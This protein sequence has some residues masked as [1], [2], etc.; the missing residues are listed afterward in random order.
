[1]RKDNVKHS[2]FVSQVRVTFSLIVFIFFSIFSVFSLYGTISLFFDA[3]GSLPWFDIIFF[4]FL[5]LIGGFGCF[6]TW[7]KK[8]FHYLVKTKVTEQTVE[9]IRYGKQI[10]KILWEDVVQVESIYLDDRPSRTQVALIIIAGH[11]ITQ[12]ERIKVLQQIGEKNDFFVLPFDKKILKMIPKNLR[13]K[14]VATVV[15]EIK[16]WPPEW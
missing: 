2:F 1:M 10:K 15:K 3:R 14:R 8:F 4:A 13:P 12:Q 11:N 16:F 5:S 6:I 9:C 7:K